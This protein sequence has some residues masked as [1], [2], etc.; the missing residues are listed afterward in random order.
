MEVA[1]PGL[2]AY[3]LAQAG[4]QS[5]FRVLLEAWSRPGRV[6]A[7]P[8]GPVGVAPV[9]LPVLALADLRS[10]MAFVGIDGAV[11]ALVRRVTGAALADVAD[12]DFVV[13]DADAATAEVVSE[14]RTGTAERP[15]DGAS[16]FVPVIALRP[17]VVGSGVVVTGPGSSS[18]T[19]FEVDG[20]G[21]DVLM[22]LDRRNER[23]PAGVDLTLVDEQGRLVGVPRSN[24]IVTVGAGLA[25]R[26][27]V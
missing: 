11:A 7:L 20:L 27:E 4:A 26:V 22:A 18:G 9:L 14:L 23:Y 8:P 19:W 15:E 25:T 12:A 3:R 21:L 10:T 13:A 16:L 2:P 24:R 1:A 17:G 6:L 5:V